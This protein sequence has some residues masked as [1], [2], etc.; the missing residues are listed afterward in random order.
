[1]P[2]RWCLN[3]VAD[4]LL[5]ITVQTIESQNIDFN[6]IVN[7]FEPTATSTVSAMASG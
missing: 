6:A 4:S 1:L 2:A 7:A 3:R 5:T